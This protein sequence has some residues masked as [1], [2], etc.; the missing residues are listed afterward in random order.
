M[1]TPDGAGDDR[2]GLRAAA[3]D[4]RVK[5]TFMKLLDKIG[6][7]HKFNKFEMVKNCYFDVEPFTIENELLTPT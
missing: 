4:P 5:S 3:N 2:V 7:G 6:K 1:P